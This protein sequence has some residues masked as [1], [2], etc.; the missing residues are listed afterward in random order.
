MANDLP[1]PDVEDLRGLMLGVI[2]DSQ[3]ESLEQHLLLCDRCDQTVDQLWAEDTLVTA[4]RG[5]ATLAEELEEEVVAGLIERLQALRTG[6]VGSATET[7]QTPIPPPA[8]PGATTSG[9]A[10]PP[11][12]AVQ[13]VYD[14]LSPP[15]GAGEIG[16]LSHY[17]ILKVLGVGGMGMVFLAEDLLLKRLVALKAMKPA[18]AGRASYRQRF[19]REAQLAAAFTHDYIVTIHQVGEDNGVPFLVMPF[20]Q[21]ETLEQRQQREHL[22][23]PAEVLRIAREIAQGLA[24]A[25]EHGLMHRDIKPGNI[26]LEGDRGRVKI[27][28]FGLAREV[29]ANVQF[30]HAGTIVGT[31]A[32]MAPEQARGEALDVRADLFSLGAVLYGLCTGDRPFKGLTAAATLLAVQ[33]DSPLPPRQLNAKVPSALSDLV[34][35]LLAKERTQRPPSAQAV[36]EALKQIERGVSSG[37]ALLP[38][39]VPRGQPAGSPRRRRLPWLLAAAVLLVGVGIAA[40]QIILRITEP[41][42]KVTEITVKK[43][44]RIEEVPPKRGPRTDG[45]P[46][47]IKPGEPLSPLALVGR[48]TP[49]PRVH[50]WTLETREQRS[51]VRAV[52]YSPD[53]LWLAVAGD[54]GTVRLWDAQTGPRLVRALVGH[55]DAVLALAW[56]PRSEILASA[57]GDGMVRL[58]EAKTGKLRRV[59][60]GPGRALTCVAFSPD[61]K[62]LAAGGDMQSVKLWDVESGDSRRTLKGHSDRV[63]SVS[64]SRDGKTLASGSLDGTVQLTEVA[65]G[66]LLHTLKACEKAGRAN[67]AVAWSPDGTTLAFTG[68]TKLRLWEASAARLRKSLEFERMTMVAWSPDGK[69]LAVGSDV[70]PTHLWEVNSDKPRKFGTSIATCVSWSPNGKAVAASCRDGSVVVRDA[71]SAKTV[72]TI[73]GCGYPTDNCAPAWSAN[74][75][76]LATGSHNNGLVYLHEAESGRLLRT[77]TWYR[78][79]YLAF[80]PDGN[81]LATAGGGNASIQ[82]WDCG[83]SKK[84]PRLEGHPRCKGVSAPIVALAF[85]PNGKVLASAGRDNAVRLWDVASGKSLGAQDADFRGAE[86]ALAWSR[87]G[88]TLAFGGLY[89]EVKL[90]EAGQPQPRR[91]LGNNTG[92]NTL[93]WSPEGATLAADCRRDKVIRCWDAASGDLQGA[94]EGHRGLI[95]TLAWLPDGKRLVSAGRDQTLRLWDAKGAQLLQ[96]FPQRL[97]SDATTMTNAF[98]PDGRLLATSTNARALRI[99]ES[100]TGRPRG[101][102][103]M[104][105]PRDSRYYLVLSPDGH[106]RAVPA[107][108]ERHLVYVVQTDAGQETLKPEE[109]ARKYHWK[110][111]PDR[112]RLTGK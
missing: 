22:L 77:L 2:A 65:S 14:F 83:G 26:W 73:Q 35:H 102:I 66:K 64:W 92:V 76:T 75:K 78:P 24:A 52:A 80:A 71:A 101:S 23:S 9:P 105:Q 42:G 72:L 95:T 29:E 31:P 110:N 97:T 62:S 28:D 106:Y 107:K 53:G 98:S 49:L 36:V 88:K 111:D 99:L 18:V 90:W 7:M 4:M 11:V 1:C 63:T 57:G 86:A 50:S 89:T 55:G 59:L 15:Q 51:V 45:V 109:F 54:D 27:L 19:L 20:L 60:A 58:W 30:T 87:D 38:P 16:R 100:E 10:A 79:C 104:L 48:P 13:E 34:M 96:T 37:P 70:I 91:A 17:R 41:D 8:S 103:A 85:S 3:A 94:L 93:A 74:G 44:Y 33:Q 84:L 25:H 43:G 12:D 68:G 21:G 47:H 82:L 6:P 40:W 112:A 39:P 46:L 56:W 108:V 5:Q 32:Y 69:T 67:V 61:G 81:T